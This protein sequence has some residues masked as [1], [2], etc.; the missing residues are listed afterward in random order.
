[1]LGSYSSL[2]RE[3]DVFFEEFSSLDTDS[4]MNIGSR[5]STESSVLSFY[6]K[7]ATPHMLEI[8]RFSGLDDEKTKF[9]I[10]LNSPSDEKNGPLAFPLSPM[11]D[12][13]AEMRRLKKELKETINMYHDACKEALME[14]QRATELEMWKKKAEKRIQLAEQ[15]AK[16]AIMKME[17]TK[18][19]VQGR[20]EADMKL[21][22]GRGGD[23]RKIVLDGLGESPIVV[24]YESL[25][26]ILVVLFL[27]YLYF[28]LRNFSFL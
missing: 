5:I 3:D 26:H 12:A 27:F 9:S 4:T 16:M 11:D 14:K 7:L 23:E 19:E 8:P 1:M 10:Y 2:S 22:R 24:K 15:T 13:E 18:L 25:L 21:V 28:T 6:E 17:T 20:V